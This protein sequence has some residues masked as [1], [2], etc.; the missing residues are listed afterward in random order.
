MWVYLN[1]L[2]LNFIFNTTIINKLGS[3]TCVNIEEGNS[4]FC[5]VGKRAFVRM[6]EFAAIKEAGIRSADG[7]ND[8]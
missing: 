5:K 7:V 4:A 3:H 2:N 8:S 6:Y 1:T